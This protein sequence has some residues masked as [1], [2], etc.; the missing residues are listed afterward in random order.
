MITN[1]NTRDGGSG[2][3]AIPKVLDPDTGLHALLH[4][5]MPQLYSDLLQFPLPSAVGHSVGVEQ[6]L[7]SSLVAG[8]EKL[9]LDEPV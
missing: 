1:S 5:L 7:D 9:G 2:Y 6:V 3:H 4:C 8:L